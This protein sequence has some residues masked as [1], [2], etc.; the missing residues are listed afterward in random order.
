[1]AFEQGCPPIRKR[2]ALHQRMQL[3]LATERLPASPEQRVDDHATDREYEHQEEP[4]EGRLRTAIV[5]DEEHRDTQ[6]VKTRQGGQELNPG[7]IRNHGAT[8]LLRNRWY[9]QATSAADNDEASDAAMRT[10]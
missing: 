6:R 2:G 3:V 5:A 1:M 7:P 8:F 4:R 10:P 9:Y